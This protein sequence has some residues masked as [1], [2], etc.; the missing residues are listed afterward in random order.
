MVLSRIGYRPDQH[1]V[2]YDDEGGGWAGR[3]AWTLDVIGHH[4]W[5][6]IDGGIH[7]L[8]Q[9]GIPLAAGA[10]APVVPTNVQVVIDAAP[11]AEIADILD[12]LDSNAQVVLDVRSHEEYVGTRVA[13][14]RA[15]HIPG[16]V[17][18]DWLRFQ[19]RNR[20][21][22]LVEGLETLLESNGITRDKR[23]ITHC[24]TH[25]RSGLSYMVL[26]LFRFPRV[27]AYHGSWSEW[28]NRDDTPITTGEEQ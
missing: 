27:Q 15:G 16:A 4:D 10:P 19:D 18:I 3:L 26:R 6:Y 12:G 25:H 7:A 20:Q 13:A 8:H 22:R 14:A 23:V 28:G 21:T 1:I 5:G 9:A 11:I 24:Q 17:N 2:V